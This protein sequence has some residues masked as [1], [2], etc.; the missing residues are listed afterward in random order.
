[1]SETNPL[2][3][4]PQESTALQGTFVLEGLEGIV[5]GLQNESWVD[6]AVSG[7]TAAIDAVDLVTDPVQQLVAMGVGW[8]LEH[9][10]PLKGWLNDLTGD[11]GAVA[12]FATTWTNIQTQLDTSATDLEVRYT[13]DVVDQTGV[14]MNTYRA[15]QGQNVDALRQLAGASGAVGMALQGC[16]FIVQ[17]VHDI[18]RDAISQVV[19]FIVD[20]GWKAF[21]LV[22]I[23]G[24]IQDVAQLVKSLALDI[25]KRVTGT[26]TSARNL[27][28]V[29]DNLSS[30]L[31]GLPDML[32]GARPDTPDVVPAARP[33][34]DAPTPRADPDRYPEDPQ[35]RRPLADENGNTVAGP[36][37]YRREDGILVPEG[38]DVDTYGLDADG[39]PL[40]G[41][42][43]RPSF[44]NGVVE[45]VWENA[46]GPDGLVRDPNTGEVI[47]WQPGDPRNGVWDMGHVPEQEYW[48]YHQEY[49]AGN[50]TRQEFLD[51]YNDPAHYQPETPSSNRGRQN[52]AP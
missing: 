15:V 24:I 10:E 39:N 33:D 31:R 35:G 17:M 41:A 27:G 48:R 6:V 52:E 37:G 11:A 8:A 19:G 7:F 18:V 29:I 2:V 26:I 46:K 20:V 3:A 42:T 21:A 49:M 51:W 16:S 44:R 36:D 47:D 12:G 1:M 43:S 34:P 4:P 50:M 9:I 14:S 28:D 23:P 22:T 5:M 45:E 32:R 25:G 13:T 38:Y 30:M 40:P